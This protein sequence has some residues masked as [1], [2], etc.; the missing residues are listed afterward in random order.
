MSFSF[1]LQF[2]T[3]KKSFDSSSQLR[4]DTYKKRAGSTGLGKDYEKLMC[5]LFAL[6]FSTSDIVADFEM[7]TNN[8]DCGDFD[9]VALKVTFV[10][11]ESQMFLLQLKHSK[12]IT[13]VTTEKLAAKNGDFSL[14]KYIKSIRTFGNAENVS[15]IL[16]TNAPTSVKNNSKICLQNKDNII[17]EV[18]VK[19]LRGLDPKKLLMNR[20]KIRSKKEGTKV[21]KFELN[22]SNGLL[23]RRDDP[24]KSFYFFAHQTNTTGAQLL[25]NSMLREE[26]G[27]NDAACSSSFIH[28]METWWSGNFILTKYD[29]VTK[30]AELMLTPFVQ[31]I[32][33]RK[34]NE[35]SKL[36]RE[37]IMKFDMTIVRD[38]N[39]EVI[40]NIWNETASDDEIR[41]ASLKYGLR[42]KG[43]KDLRVSPKERSKVL[44][45]LNKVPLIVKAEDCRKE[46]VKHAVRLLEK[47]EKKKVI[48]LLNATRGEFPGWNIF[49][50]LSDIQNEG[51]YTD[52]V[53]HFAV[54]LQGRQSIFL[55]QLLN[56]AHENCKTFETTELIK[57][58]QEVIQIGRRQEEA[59]E[60][61][62]PRSVSTI[63]LDIMKKP[64]FC[65]KTGSLL[66]ICDVSEPWN[67]AIRQLDLHVM[68]LDQYLE[69]EEK[70]KLSKLDVLL[71]SNKWPQVQ[72]NDICEKTKRNVHLLQVFNDKSCT[73]VLSKEKRFSLETMKSERVRVDE[74][75]IFTYLDHPLNVICSPPGMGKSTLM[76][77]LSSICPSSYWSVRANLI[78]HQ[79]VFKKKCVHEEILHH[80]IQDVEDP[81]VVKIRSILLQNRRI[82]FFLDGLD[83]IDSDCIPLALD[84]IKYISS[85]GHRVWITS[86]EN[87]EQTLLEELNIF[88]IKIE[89]LTE[90]QQKTYIQKRL[91][92][93]Y[94]EDEVDQITNKIYESVD[95]VNSRHLLG[96]PL[97]LFMVTENFRDNKDLWTKPDQEI[98]V[99]TKMYKIFFQGKK[100]HQLRKVGMHE[101]EDQ[102]GFDFDLYLEQYELPALESCLDTTTF[103]KLKTNLGTSQNFLEKLK[104]GDPFGIVSGVT[105]DNQVIFTHQ[106]YAEYFAC[107]WLKNNLDKVSLLQ[108]DLFTKRNQN[109]KV[110]FDIMLAE[111]SALHLAVIY[112]NTDL[113]LNHLDKTKVNN[114][115]GRSPLHLLC[116]YG[117]EHPPLC[118][119]VDC[120][121]FWHPTNYHC[122]EEIIQDVPSTQYREIFKMLS[123]CDV[124]QND[125][126]FQWNCLDYAIRHHNLFAVD[127][128]LERFGDSISLEQLFKHYGIITLAYYSSQ[129]GYAN[130]L[131]TAITKDSRALSVKIGTCN[132]TLLH[133]AIIKI[134]IDK[135]RQTL[136]EESIK[137]MTTLIEYGLDVNEQCICKRTALHFASALDDDVI[138]KLLLQRGANV[139]LI[140]YVGRNALHY[141]LR[142]SKVNTTIV[143]LLIDKMIDAEA[144]DYDG[145]TPLRLCCRKGHFDAL[146]IL[147]EKGASAN[148]KNC[149]LHDAIFK[150]N[151]NCIKGL[152][153]HGADINAVDDFGTTALHAAFAR[154]LSPDVELIQLLLNHGCDANKRDENQK[155][156]L[157]YAARSIRSHRVLNLLLDARAHDQLM[158]TNVTNVTFLHFSIYEGNCFAVEEFL[159]IGLDLDKMDVNNE[160]YPL[161]FAVENQHLRSDLLLKMTEFIRD[162]KKKRNFGRKRIVELLE[163]YFSKGYS[164]DR[165]S[166]IYQFAFF[167]FVFFLSYST[168]KIQGYYI[169]VQV[170]VKNLWLPPHIKNIKMM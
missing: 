67:K 149:A 115:G 135:F 118:R 70:R 73:P 68:E 122:A 142:N 11:G 72:F 4:F 140:D 60:T 32:S 17:E 169:I 55:D 148:A 83:E 121:S 157:D 170:G 82:Y 27:I 16:Y 13:D 89:E 112:R 167:V 160:E 58:T 12:N 103:D 163:E 145:D 119:H 106:T 130:L 166:V 74:M 14:L 36:L 39:E 38:M 51:V 151:Y 42:P 87:L 54:S 7:K 154:G 77:R 48:L 3:K 33:D 93:I 88:P 126:V 111:N 19:E 159:N 104:T 22:Q 124:F 99:L 1:N 150:G 23:K 109:L 43:I 37:A 152:L 114:D 2:A 63:S 164:F 132:L 105:D 18:V 110:L 29:V 153:D 34:C 56:F 45:H 49:Q 62:I 127:K 116:A 46:Q 144:K 143:K 15:F 10:D 64:E 138:V 76:S 137:V 94:Q 156:A 155:T 139:N 75:E 98:F 162:C 95:I 30:L 31:T 91:Q 59:F 113:I 158:S 53:K 66:I 92:N 21:L 107:A 168:Y 40:A 26:C 131:H 6:K 79:R 141:A 5:A 96:V 101:H 71:T 134:K 61:Y 44:W 25:I 41:L 129:M 120:F 50:D 117:V 86:R 90:E 24:L 81:L 8:D 146:V 84:F 28:F 65:K 80:F 165:V 161:Y 123:H 100:M 52:I 133:A 78:T 128:L 147:L 97:Q 85:L 125:N 69:L 47:V 20:N 57:M 102:I 108:D 9:D 136:M 35:K